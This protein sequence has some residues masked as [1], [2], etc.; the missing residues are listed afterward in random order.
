MFLS[1]MWSFDRRP[2]TRRLSRSEAESLPQTRVACRQRCSAWF[3]SKKCEQNEQSL[4]HGF[5]CNLPPGL[6]HLIWPRHSLK[7]FFRSQDDSEPS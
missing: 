7:S 3:C 6:M 5:L 2:G 4:G 1:Q